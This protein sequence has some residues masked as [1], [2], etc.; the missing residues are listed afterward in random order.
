MS[1][2]SGQPSSPS[3]WLS[4]LAPWLA[5]DLRRETGARRTAEIEAQRGR[6]VSQAVL[7]CVSDGIVVTDHARRILQINVAAE[8]VLGVT[9]DAAIGVDLVSLL[10]APGD[11]QQGATLERQF[12]LA[13]PSDG[14]V[15]IELEA[16]RKH[17]ERFPA[18]VSVV[19]TLAG[20][21][22]TFVVSIRDVSERRRSEAAM[23]E[24][25]SMTALHE[26][27]GA[28]LTQ[29]TDMQTML[30]P[31]TD[32][33]VRR[34]KA[35]FAGVWALD[36]RSQTLTLEAFCD[37]DIHVAGAYDRVAVGEY[38]VGVVAR[39]RRPYI[40]RSGGTARDATPMPR[41]TADAGVAFAGYP[42]V[43]DG[44][45]VG[46]LAVFSRDP[47]SITAVE[48]LAGVADS[49]ALGV[50]RRQAERKVG[51]VAPPAGSH[52]A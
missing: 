51:E 12:T 21:G 26:S 36:D 48:A 25:L 7:A 9:S 17:G 29:G 11:R 43:V 13:A 15:T 35:G 50:A 20:D 10:I 52:A 16:T 38:L 18:Q 23:A 8:H 42:L 47:L 3:R 27:A 22:L 19:R 40:C 45:T 4:A 44:Q 28:A 5:R 34:L 14:H 39:D 49:V 6:A 2:P 31:V 24:R 33:L 46:V 37:H 1:E 32:T 30:Q 41:V